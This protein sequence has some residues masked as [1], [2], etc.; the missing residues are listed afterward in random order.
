MA[1]MAATPMPSSAP[2]VV[3]SAVS[4]SPSLTRP[5]RPS[6][7]SYGL[8]G[9]ALAHHVQVCLKD[10][11]RSALATMGGRHSHHQVAPPGRGGLETP[12][13]RPLPNVG[14]RGVLA[15]RGTWD[16]GERLEEAPYRLG[17]ET[18]QRVR[19]G[20]LPRK[21]AGFT[22]ERTMHSMRM[23]RVTPGCNYAL[24]PPKWL[25]RADYWSIMV[26]HGPSGGRSEASSCYD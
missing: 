10:Q 26:R 5:M 7:G 6:V 23:L 1:I 9:R 8:S 19:H 24:K 22:C 12:T 3:P 20:I 21:I 2:S 4:H 14:D 17:L 15:T 18:L 13:A 16:R 25:S 11:G